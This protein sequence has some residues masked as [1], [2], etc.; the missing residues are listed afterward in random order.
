LERYQA[1]V[2]VHRHLPMKA[3]LGV[4]CHNDA[5]KSTVQRKAQ[6]SGHAMKVVANTGWYV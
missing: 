1:E 6:A 3:M 5:V 4:V 2:L